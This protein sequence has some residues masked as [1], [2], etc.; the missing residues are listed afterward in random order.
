MDNKWVETKVLLS[1][2]EIEEIENVRKLVPFDWTFEETLENMLLVGF[3]HYI[4]EKIDFFKLIY[5]E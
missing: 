1:V 5:S 4:D 3:K 2:E